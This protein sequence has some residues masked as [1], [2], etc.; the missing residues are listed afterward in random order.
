MECEVTVAF[1]ES[2]W[3]RETGKPKD[4]NSAQLIKFLM[5]LQ[6]NN[7]RVWY[8]PNPLL[9]AKVLYIEEPA[10]DGS[11]S[12]RALVTSANFTER[13]L[14]GANFELGVVFHDLDLYSHLKERVEK[15]TDGVLGAGRSLEDVVQTV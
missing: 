14:C 6:T 2:L 3:N 1:G 12:I 10:E 15:F 13:A 4:E 8:V 11:E 5:E 7:A 9:H